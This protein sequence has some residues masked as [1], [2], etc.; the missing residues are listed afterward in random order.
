VAEATYDVV[1]GVAGGLVLVFSGFT[2]YHLTADPGAACGLVMALDQVVLVAAVLAFW[3][4]LRRKIPIDWAHSVTVLFGWLVAANVATSVIVQGEGSDL[5][6]MQATVIGAGAI[7]LSSRAFALILS[8]TAAM[9]LPAAAVVCPRDQLID[10]VVMQSTTSLVSI[11]LYYTRLRSQKKLLM[12]RQRTAQTAAELGR[13]LARAEHEFAEHERS[14]QKRRELEEQL[15]QAQKLE[16][17][18]TLA[19]GVAHDM[20]N[21]LGAITAIAST[22]LEA[23]SVD[24]EAHQELVDVLQTARRGE[25]LTRNILS[26]ARRG[27]TQSVPFRVDAV[28]VDIET[29]LKRTLPKHIMLTV[30]CQAGEC[31]VDG[32]AGQIGHLLTNLC[33]NS[34]DAIEG[35]GQIQ[36]STRPVE[37]DGDQADKL[38]T[39]AGSHV[40]LS[41]SDD[42]QGIAA[43]V[44]TRVFEPYFSTKLQQPHSGLGLSMVYGT[45][46]QHKGSIA[47]RSTV[48]QGTT[49]TVFLPTLAHAPSE[50]KVRR[51][52]GTQVGP[53]RKHL[54]FVDDEPMLRRAGERIA[55]SL[56]FEVL[57]ACDGREAL[58]LFSEHRS[59]VGAVVLDVAMPV[60]SGAECCRTLRQWDSAL[61]IVLVSGFPKDHDIQTL[62]ENAH[63]RYVRKP[64][65][66]DELAE[67]LVAVLGDQRTSPAE[68][69]DRGS[70]K[71]DPP[72]KRADFDAG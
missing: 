45:V 15:R 58:G 66:R 54:L 24:S 18:G 22:A 30:D 14:D 39:A 51:C 6:Y 32:D 37:L 69:T 28:V 68:P 10:F 38:G 49:V 60:M 29:L 3:L 33:L 59:R 55:K 1:R 25:T 40:E 57:V 65:D 11:A 61:P 63:T 70:R 31:W 8:G 71:P 13:A 43:E 35:R 56:G 5:Q 34:A 27:P 44:L 23:H 16:A 36:V 67:A 12:L 26:F 7:V 53:V 21:V 2:L 46:Q 52:H 9:A 42:G 48:G 72:Q 17:L 19:G 47:I 20:N 50:S 4:M 62:L 41:V 64:Y